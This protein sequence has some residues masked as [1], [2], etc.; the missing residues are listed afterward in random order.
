MVIV[1]SEPRAL[2]GDVED[3]EDDEIERISSIWG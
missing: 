2:L 3:V 1:H